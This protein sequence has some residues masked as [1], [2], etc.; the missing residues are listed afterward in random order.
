M[1]KLEENRNVL[2]DVTTYG[3]GRIPVPE[4]TKNS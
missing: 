3:I 4:G 1:D 2:R